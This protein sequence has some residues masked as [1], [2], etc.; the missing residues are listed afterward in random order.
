MSRVVVTGRIPDAAI[1]KLRAEHEVDAWSGPESIGR[2]ELLRRVARADAI[3]SL[4]TERVDAELLDAAGPQLKVVANVAVGYDNIDVPA[5]TERGVVATNTPGVL[6]EATADIAF[7]LIL[8][9]TRRLGEGERLIR[10]GQAWKWGMFFL[11][12]SSL[13]GKT[14]GIVGMGGIGQATARRAKAFGMEIVYQ[15]RSEVDPQIAA[16]L[17]ARRVD[18][19]ELLAVADVVSLHCPYGPA[20][21]HL[22]GAEQL[23]AMKNSAFL[24]NTARGPIV[25]EDALATALREGVIAGAGLDV[26]EKEPSVHPELLGL[27]NVALVPHLGSATV[28]TRTAMA[29]LA[30]DNALAVLSGEQPPAPIA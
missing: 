24:I 22:I 8:M 29:M 19:D 2:D 15:S 3:V 5:C 12:G 25:N 26:F 21:H 9:A 18:L 27:D 30:A 14:L 10:S 23:A 11:L 7:G 6:I 28:E 1:E 4:L 17:D 16:E 13:Q 20:T